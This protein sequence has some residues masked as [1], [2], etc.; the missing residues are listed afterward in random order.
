MCMTESDS[1][2]TSQIGRYFRWHDYV[3]DSETVLGIG[4][5]YLPDI[6]SEFTKF[7]DSSIDFFSNPFF[8]PF[9]KVLFRY[10][11]SYSCKVF[12]IPDGWIDNRR[13]LKTRRIA[14]IVSCHDLV[15]KCCIFDCLGEGSWGIERTC[16]R[17]NSSAG[18]TTIGWFESD[19]TTHAG[20]LSDRSSRIS[21]EG[22]WNHACSNCCCRSRGRP[23]GNPRRIPRVSSNSCG[24]VFT[25]SSHGKFIHIKLPDTR[26]SCFFEEGYDRSIVGWL[27]TRQ[28]F[29]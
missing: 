29:G 17:D 20:W 26:K 13:F 21:T 19:D 11:D 18:V 6:R 9:Y 3:V 7:C 24:T 10:P 14:R 23:S 5:T 15:E 4:K 8:Y 22:C 16:H 1:I 12:S 25:T 2:V 27:I 28:H